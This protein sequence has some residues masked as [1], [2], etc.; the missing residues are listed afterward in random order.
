MI[1]QSTNHNKQFHFLIKPSEEPLLKSLFEVIVIL[2]MYF[3]ICSLKKK[4]SF[5]LID[6][7]LNT[8]RT[9]ERF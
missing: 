1:I 3:Y 7:I 6:L 4:G 2:G 8:C 9:E 5:N